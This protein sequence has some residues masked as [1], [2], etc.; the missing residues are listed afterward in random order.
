MF[1]QQLKDEREKDIKIQ[2]GN[3]FNKGSEKATYKEKEDPTSKM[4]RLE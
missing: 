3:I 4:N 1:K 2:E